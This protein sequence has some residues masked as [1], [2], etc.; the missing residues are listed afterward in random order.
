MKLFEWQAS[1]PYRVAFSTRLGG[2]S[3]G[4]FESLNLGIL[5][6]DDP[7]RVVENRKR[8][9]R[10]VEADAETATMAWQR[11]GNVV[12]EAKPRGIVERTIYGQCDGLWSDR[13]GQA[14]LLLTADCYPVAITRA[15]G[16]PGLCVLHVGW[17][18]LLAGIVDSGA[19]ALGHGPL[20]AAVGPG[21]GSCCY[22]VGEEVA[23]PFRQR[24]GADVTVDGRLDLG[25]ATERALH[26]AGVDSVERSAHCTSC[27]PELFFSHRR[28]SGRTGR[29]GVIAYIR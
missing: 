19:T 15:D 5:T 28:D 8:L 18:G 27:E 10:A 7:D 26:E 3:E 17:R 11:H 14:M 2:V 9:S 20:A 16:D 13:R 1:G 25:L 22:E 12:T 29:Q 24:F 21:I 23:G 4:E 6:D